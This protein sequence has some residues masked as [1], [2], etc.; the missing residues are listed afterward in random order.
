M[1]VFNISASAIF[2]AIVFLFYAPLFYLG[3]LSQQ[4]KRAR[5]AFFRALLTILERDQDDLQCVPE[6]FM[7]YKK[8]LE[9]HP[10][11]R[12][13]YR[14]AVNFVEDF[15]FRA[16]SYAPNRFKYIYG[17]DV[18]QDIRKRI[19]NIVGL[20]KQT[21]PF[22]SV[23]SKYSGLLSMLN[24]ALDTNN[25]DLGKSMIDQMADDIEILERTIYS[26][27]RTNLASIIV[28][29]VGLILTIVFGVVAILPLIFPSR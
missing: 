6:I 22:S 21:E 8:V 13:S 19:V 29:V 18:S 23:S 15:L 24:H 5:K 11:V 20:M 27:Q 3:Y 28:S 10:S 14:S 12:D 2:I 9:L 26:Q 17:L 25:V 4:K 7:M 16:D 1:E